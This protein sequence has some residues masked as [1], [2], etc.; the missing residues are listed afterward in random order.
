MKLLP[1]KIF[2]RSG[3]WNFWF[4]Y[5]CFTEL[6][7]GQVV[8]Y[9]RDRWQGEKSLQTWWMLYQLIEVTQFLNSDHTQ[10]R[11]LWILLGRQVKEIKMRMVS[12]FGENYQG[13]KRKSDR[14]D[15]SAYKNTFKEM[16][17][18]Q[19]STIW[20]LFNL[21]LHYLV[22]QLL[23]KVKCLFITSHRDKQISFKVI[24]I[25][26][27]KTAFVALSNAASIVSAIFSLRI[28]ET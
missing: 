16:L 8:L 11:R 18:R 14:K 28:K 5:L 21:Q 1:S 23:R 9:E 3:D 19:T 13:M 26:L 4:K 24:H 7:T 20:Q 10:T 17:A 6:Y 15:L 25:R 12:V 22:R 2:T 27:C